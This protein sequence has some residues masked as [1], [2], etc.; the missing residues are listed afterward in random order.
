[1]GLDTGQ[2]VMTWEK[3]FVIRIP[4][5]T[6]ATLVTP[7]R[8]TEAI[9]EILR[10]AGKPLDRET[11]DEVIRTTTLDLSGMKAAEYRVDGRFVQDFGLD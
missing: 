9:A 10:T 2:L 5:E 4:N 8:A 11:I 1:M 6:T 3:E 7:R